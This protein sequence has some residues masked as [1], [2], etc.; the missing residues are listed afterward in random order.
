MYLYV[1]FD[2]HLYT[3]TC[4]CTRLSSVDSVIVCWSYNSGLKRSQ[5]SRESVAA[6][7]VSIMGVRSCACTMYLCCNYYSVKYAFS[8]MC[9]IPVVIT[10][11]LVSICAAK[12]SRLHESLV[13]V[14]F[15][16]GEVQ[17]GTHVHIHV[18]VH[19]HLQIPLSNS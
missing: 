8:L 6:S 19:V 4:R 13:D 16:F 11:L 14:S 15:L 1:Y 12:Q 9:R 18:H 3:C 7:H 17:V 2:L 5:T 10:V